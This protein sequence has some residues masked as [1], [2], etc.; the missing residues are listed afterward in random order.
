MTI[1]STFLPL[2]KRLMYGEILYNTK[3]F[4]LNIRLLYQL[5][6]CFSSFDARLGHPHEGD[7]SAAAAE[8]RVVGL[9]WSLVERS[10]TGIANKL[11]NLF[12]A[13]KNIPEVFSFNLSKSFKHSKVNLLD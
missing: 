10:R 8:R 2:V 12:H 11:T 6:F 1:K 5:F 9:D 3:L 7:G 13:K 4:L